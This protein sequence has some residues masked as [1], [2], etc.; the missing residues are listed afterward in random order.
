MPDVV[1]FEFSAKD[2]GYRLYPIADR[3]A[4]MPSWFKKAQGRQ[5]TGAGEKNSV[6]SLTWPNLGTEGGNQCWYN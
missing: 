1:R 2:G 3:H 4:F 6:C 5:T